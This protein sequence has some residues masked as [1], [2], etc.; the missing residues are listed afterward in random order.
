WPL[1]GA[2]PE[3]S[4]VHGHRSTRPANLDPAAIRRAW[5]SAGGNLPTAARLLGVHRATLYRSL[6]RLGLDRNALSV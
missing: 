6:A 4:A 2:P 5:R 1:P 3:T